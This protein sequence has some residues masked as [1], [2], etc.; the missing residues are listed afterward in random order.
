MGADNTGQEREK[1]FDLAV[2]GAGPAG[3]LIAA[4]TAEA[5]FATV[6]LEQKKLP[7]PKI[8]GGFIS[9][10]CLSLLPKDMTL[11]AAGIPVSEVRVIR[12]P[13]E[14]CYKAEK[15]LG[16]L[17]R[18][19]DFDQALADYAR[20]R[21]AL[22]IE[23]RALLKLA[24]D[25]N[26]QGTRGRVFLLFS[27]PGN[28]KPIRARYLVGADGAL[29]R[30]SGMAGLKGP[31]VKVTGWGLSSIERVPENLSK[32]GLLQFY[33]LPLLGGMGWAFHGPGWV[34]RGVGGLRGRKALFRAYGNLFPAG[35]QNCPRPQAWPLPFLGPL[36]K[37][38][39]GNL[40]LVGDAAGLIDPFSGEGLYN[41]LKSSRL[42]FRALTEAREGKTEAGPIYDRLFLNH[43]RLACGPA[44]AGA[45]LL[46]IH[47]LINPAGLP[48]AMA[49]LM[50]N[51]LWFNRGDG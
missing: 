15:P 8:C 51:R 50:E 43:F 35:G 12:G 27:G 30:F 7:R 19:E 49:A 14:Y 1:I 44:L 22:L 5:G 41:S 39:R 33:P 21:G 25:K 40:L 10:R 36:R 4:L 29:G 6:I 3:S 13:K 26:G 34:N 23:G 32:M 18:R 46:H 11:P 2:I 37:V 28:E 38:S 42:A 45:A 16:L 31:S 20:S 9:A 17:T 48:R 47:G 24:E